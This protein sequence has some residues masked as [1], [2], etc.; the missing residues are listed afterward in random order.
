MGAVRDQLKAIE[1][2]ILRL[3]SGQ[4][5]RANDLIIPPDFSA[6]PNPRLEA[7]LNGTG[8]DALVRGVRRRDAGDDDDAVRACL[9]DVGR[10]LLEMWADETGHCPQGGQGQETDAVLQNLMQRVADTTRDRLETFYRDLPPGRRIVADRRI[11]GPIAPLREVSRRAEVT[12]EA[13]RQHQLL[14]TKAILALCGDMF[15]LLGC[16]IRHRVLWHIERD[17]RIGAVLAGFW[18]DDAG[19]TT[20]PGRATALAHIFLS[21][22]LDY[23]AKDGVAIDSTARDARGVLEARAREIADDAGLVFLEDLEKFAAPYGSEWIARAEMLLKRSALHDI[24]S[25]LQALADPGLRPVARPP[26]KIYALRPTVKALTKAALITIG[27]PATRQEVGDVSG[28]PASRAASYLSGFGGI[29]RAD[30]HHWGLAEWIDEPYGGIVGEIVKILEREGGSAPVALLQAELASRCSVTNSSIYSYAKTQRF[31]LEKGIVSLSERGDVRLRPLKDAVSGT[32]RDGHPYWNFRY[33]DRF[34]EGYSL[35]GV[36]FEILDWLG[37]R[38]ES[39]SRL[40]LEH[41]AGCILTA[42]WRLSSTAGGY[43]GFLAEPVRRIEEG[44][45]RKLRNGTKLRLTLLDKGLAR[46]D[47]RPG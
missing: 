27:R 37:C 19:S 6:S 25:G 20:I 36:P 10:I 23:D 44:L 24:S 34:K 21:K 16:Y 2:A 26:R 12:T 4:K 38:P 17:E 5:L 45:G 31:H 41:P 13:A 8:S 43:F 3:R 22:A 40:R 9:F 11:I 35:T 15:D 29:V 47:H 14:A 32:D 1:P 33:L 7:I 39:K 30:K 28:V 42:H 18:P 46:I